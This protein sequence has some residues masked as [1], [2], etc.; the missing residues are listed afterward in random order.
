[1]TLVTSW[2]ECRVRSRESSAPNYIAK[3]RRRKRHR[4]RQSCKPVCTCSSSTSRDVT[5][6]RF[7]VYKDND[8]MDFVNAPVGKGLPISQSLRP[9]IA[10]KHR[11]ML[12][13]SI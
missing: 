3:R 4:H 12:F 11:S 10:G 7:T 13:F 6:A 5:S 1:M 2:R 9:L 8:L